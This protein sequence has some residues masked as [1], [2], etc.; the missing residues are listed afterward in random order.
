MISAVDLARVR[1]AADLVAIAGEHTQLKRVGRQW[2]ATCPFH[3]ERTPLL[4]INAEEGLWWCFGCQQGGDAITFVQ[5]IHHLEFVDA[6]EW[7]AARAGI[8]LSPQSGEANPGSKTQLVAITRQ[9]AEWYHGQL[10]NNAEAQPARDYLAGRGVTQE[11]LEDYQV[12]WAPAGWDNLVRTLNVPAEVAI[13]AGVAKTNRAGRLQDMFRG[14]ITFPIHDVAG[15]VI[16]FGARLLADGE[17]PKYLNSPDSTLYEKSRAL[18]GLHRAKSHIVTAGATVVC[19]GYLDVIGAAAADISTAVAS[20]GTA[21]GSQH[22][23]LLGRFADRVVLAFDADTAG[24]KAAAR[25]HN[26]EAQQTCLRPGG[27]AGHQSGRDVGAVAWPYLACLVQI[28]LAPGSPLHGC[29]KLE[30]DE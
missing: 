22:L 9:A 2:M 19:E 17:G 13:A 6:V 25:L 28:S 20:C 29:S 21:L 18:Y 24:A 14:R 30:R 12:G 23:Q 15:N 26:L 3:E 5:R 10:L 1:A 8:T 27:D 11:L 4:S 7:L 16:G